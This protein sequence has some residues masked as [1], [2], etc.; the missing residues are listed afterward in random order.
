MKKK[1]KIENSLKIYPVPKEDAEK[2]KKPFQKLKPYLVL[3]YLLKET[4]EAHVADSATIIKY[5]N[6][7]GIYAE[8]R[9]I[10]KDVEV[11]NQ[12]MWLLQKNKKENAFGMEDAEAA[13]AEDYDDE[14]KFV[15]YDKN[16][17]GYYVRQRRYNLNDIR[18]LAECVY[19]SKF[20]SQAQA[21]RLSDIVF[22]FVSKNQAEKI[23]HNA[24]VVDRVKTTNKNV[25]DS[26]SVINDAMSTVLDGQRHEPC[27]IKFQYMKH[28]INNL[29]QT[30]NH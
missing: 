28:T 21:N 30:V 16:R 26:I 8:R 6:D 19:S 23:K 15:V 22:D 2:G 1:D 12:V 7:I 29:K 25:L 27:K 11:I 5:L 20:I 24:I 10:Y 3:Q 9:S 14:E 13:I 18:L 17:K 4:D